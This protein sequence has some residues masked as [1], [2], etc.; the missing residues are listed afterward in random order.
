MALGTA[1]K[2]SA[3]LSRFS[4]IGCCCGDESHPPPEEP[5]V[6]ES[7]LAKGAK[8]SLAL[9]DDIWR[10]WRGLGLCG[11]SGGPCVAS[12]L[13]LSA[14]RFARCSRITHDLPGDVMSTGRAGQLAA[15]RGV[16]GQLAIEFLR[17]P[18]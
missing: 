8:S 10:I 17:C 3:T 12:S 16:N 9:K 14:A 13:A 6:A 7:G 11:V 2:A 1:R 15:L 18:S 5:E 4:C